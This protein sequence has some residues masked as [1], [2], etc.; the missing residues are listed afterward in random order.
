MLVGSLWREY[1]VVNMEFKA[2]K[3]GNCSRHGKRHELNREIWWALKERR[4]QGSGKIGIKEK[5][6]LEGRQDTLSVITNWTLNLLA[7]KKYNLWTH[8]V[9]ENNF[10]MWMFSKWSLIFLS[11]NY[12]SCKRFMKTFLCIIYSHRIT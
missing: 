6:K 3:S 11:L 2:I 12:L 7:R 8:L 5:L 10:M 1:E 9:W 4:I